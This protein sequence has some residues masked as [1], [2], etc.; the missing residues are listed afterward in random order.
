MH[1]GFFLGSETLVS[2]FLV[3]YFLYLTSWCRWIFQN[4]ILCLFPH[5][6]WHYTLSMIIFQFFFVH[7]M[8]TITQPPSI[9]HPSLFTLYWG[10]L[11]LMCYISFEK[12]EIQLIL[13]INQSSESWNYIHG[14]PSYIV[15]PKSKS[16]CIMVSNTFLLSCKVT[17]GMILKN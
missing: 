17:N 13:I 7:L 1:K 8:F 11:I 9:T 5:L 16:L 12:S 4:G 2:I 3:R 10:Y 6:L 14:N 15:K